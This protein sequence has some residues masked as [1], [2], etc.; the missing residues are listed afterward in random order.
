MGERFGLVRKTQLSLMI[1]VIAIAVMTLGTLVLGGCQR[2]EPQTVRLVMGYI[3]NV[4]FAPWYVAQEKGYFEDAGLEITMDYGKVN[5]VMRLL[6]AGEIDFV[7]A[8]GDEVIV[9]RSQDLPVTYVM[10]LYARFPAAV[11]SLKEA[12]INEPADLRGKTIGL[13]GF[14]GTNYIAIKAILARLGMTESDVNLLPVGYNQVAVLSEGKVDAIVGFDNNEPIQLHSLGFETNVIHSYDYFDLVGHGV[15]TGEKQLQENPKRVQAFVTATLRGME[16]ALQHPD[17]AFEI[18]LKFAPESGGPNAEVQKQVM[19]ESMKLWQSAFTD[20]H[21]LGSS[22]PEAWT[23]SQQ[24]M[25]EWG[26]ISKETP[27]ELL[28]TNDYIDY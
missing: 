14:Y 9:A 1:L 21:G 10:A 15:V 27:A 3:P 12:A 2:K 19:L 23:A 4:Q 20:A 8:G 25:L 16:Y 6:A 24:S 18:C 17:E 11:V 13:P 26:L 5:D 22:D 28:V 7:I